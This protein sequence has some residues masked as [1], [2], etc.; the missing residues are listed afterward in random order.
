LQVM[1]PS[2]SIERIVLIVLDSVGCGEL[3]DAAKYGDSGADTLG[4]MSVRVGGMTLPHLQQLGLGSLT[5]ILGVPPVAAARGAYG[6]MREASSGKDTTTGHWEMC[7][8]QVTAPFPT[9]EH[10]FPRELIERFEREIGRGVLGN[11]PASGTAILD[12]LGVEHMR[13]GKVIVYT[14]A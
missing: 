8:L 12:E 11:K 14:S 7:G 1:T 6:K 3:P 5:T 10:G 2:S 4:N 9:F 13:T